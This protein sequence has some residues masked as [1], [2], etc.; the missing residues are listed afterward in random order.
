M[1]QMVIVD[2]SLYD[3]LANMLDFI[4]SHLLARLQG[5]NIVDILDELDLIDS[6]N[7]V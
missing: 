4:E 2:E 1:V 5:N 7:G 6:E 3:F